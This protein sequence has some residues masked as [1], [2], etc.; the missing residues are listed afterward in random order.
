MRI[1]CPRHGSQAVVLAC[2]HLAEAVAQGHP[3]PQSVRVDAEY[4]GTVVWGVSLCAACAEQQ[5]FSEASQVLYGE[6]GLDRVFELPQQS[7]ICSACFAEARMQ[8]IVRK[9]DMS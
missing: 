7:P 1:L 6:A 9:R 2:P 3:L 5:G 8:P 4:K